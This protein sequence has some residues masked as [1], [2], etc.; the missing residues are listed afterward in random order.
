MCVLKYQS[1]STFLFF[2]SRQFLLSKQYSVTEPIFN[3]CNIRNY[4]SQVFPELGN[5]IISIYF[6][7]FYEKVFL[8]FFLELSFTRTQDL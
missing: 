2:Y 3:T 6:S 5:I 1:C 4:L 7:C 8:F